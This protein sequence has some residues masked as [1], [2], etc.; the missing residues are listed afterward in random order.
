MM[1]QL[2]NNSIFKE[3][4]VKTHSEFLDILL[5]QNLPPKKAHFMHCARTVPT[6][7]LKT[8]GNY[9]AQKKSGAFL[10]HYANLG[11]I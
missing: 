1:C 7:L 5:N 4:L 10:I 11:D 8:R 6:K 9:V 2:S 3:M